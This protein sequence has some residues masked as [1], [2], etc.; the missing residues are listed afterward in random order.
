MHTCA[1]CSEK[2]SQFFLFKMHGES[3]R[4]AVEDYGLKR[5]YT[6]EEKAMLV[7]RGERRLEIGRASC[8][9]RV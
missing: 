1:I 5:P 6:R 7:A 3:H 4:V 9:E 2:F 8:R